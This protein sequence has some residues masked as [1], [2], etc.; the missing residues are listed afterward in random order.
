M[1]RLFGMLLAALLTVAPSAEG[2]PDDPEVSQTVAPLF[3]SHSPLPV[4]IEAPLT[5]LMRDRPIDDYLDGTFSFEKDDGTEQSL[6]LKIRTRGKFRRK[7][8]HCD[9]APIRLNFRK[10]QV[11]DTV[12]AGQD[13]LKLVTHC[14]NNKSY[15]E[16]LILREYL[17]YRFLNVMTDSSYR[18]RLLKINYVDTEGTEP[19][20]KLG[21]V[22][23]D[24]DDVAERIGMYSIKSGN[25]SD[26]ALDRAEQNFINVF[27]YMIGNTEF[28]LVKGEPDAFCCHNIDLMSAT[29]R[30]PFVPLAYDFDFAGLVNAPYAGPNPRFKLANVRQRLYRGLCANNDLLPS[31]IQRFLDKKDA[32]YGAV[33]E[34]ELLSSRSRRDVTGYLKTFYDRISKPKSVES[35][36]VKKCN[37][38]L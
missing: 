5:T 24:N 26:D 23:E 9:F 22:I 21:F 16:Q 20:T 18:V 15:Y 11:T 19:M 2:R 27:Q 36:F 33:D 8:K 4:T 34:L 30:A 3:S 29:K 32:I 35:V 6:D 17:A 13:K 14:Q 25:I 31:T 7:E 1:K 28:S 10:K 12:F 37:D 38:S